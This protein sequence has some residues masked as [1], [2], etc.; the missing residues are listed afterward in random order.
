MQADHGACGAHRHAQLA[1]QAL[2]VIARHD[3]LEDH[4]RSGGEQAS[5]E[6]RTFGVIVGRGHRVFDASQAFARRQPGDLERQRHVV[7]VG[8]AGRGLDQR[9]TLHQRR[10]H[11]FHAPARQRR[12]AD[13]ARRKGLRGEHPGQQARGR[14][15]MP[16]INLCRGRLEPGQAHAAQ[17]NGPLL[18]VFETHTEGAERAQRAEI[19]VTVG[20]AAELAGPIGERRQD[21]RSVRDAAVTR[22][23]HAALERAVLGSH[24]Q[25][26]GGHGFCAKALLP[27]YVGNL[28]SNWIKAAPSKPTTNAACLPLA[29]ACNC[30]TGCGTPTSES[31]VPYVPSFCAKACT[32]CAPCAAPAA[33]PY[34]NVP[35][36]LTPG[37]LK[38][39][40]KAMVSSPFK[41]ARLLLA[42]SGSACARR[43][44]PA[45]IGALFSPS[46]SL[47]IQGKVC[48]RTRPSRTRS[49]ARRMPVSLPNKAVWSLSRQKPKPEAVYSVRPAYFRLAIGTPCGVFSTPFTAASILALSN[50]PRATPDKSTPCIEYR[51]RYRCCKSRAGSKPADG[52]TG[53]RWLS[54][55]S[56][57]PPKGEAT[58]SVAFSEAMP[59]TP[60]GKSASG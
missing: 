42:A 60:P 1:H 45:T 8:A 18:I 54:R 48:R 55:A 23:R 2:G 22:H 17:A 24:D 40:T 29:S 53:K 32:F 44:A 46:S 13:Q 3:G 26:S 21:Q 36:K 6:Q 19:V 41:K 51:P 10:D 58:S 52:G 34:T 59:T 9:A 33:S 12:A 14:G 28:S 25:T 50:L 27:R 11:G 20:K 38:L 49:S 15:R 7:R 5:E 56:K 39:P 37:S 31:S 57:R 30:R 43:S 35:A 16:T 47:S 4:G